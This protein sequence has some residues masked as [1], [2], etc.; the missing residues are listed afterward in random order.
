MTHNQQYQ[1]PITTMVNMD[2]QQVLCSSGSKKSFFDMG[3]VDDGQN[4]I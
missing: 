4:A 2:T 3:N 1:T